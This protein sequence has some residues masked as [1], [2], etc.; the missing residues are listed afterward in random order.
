MDDV[1]SYKPNSFRMLR[2]FWKLSFVKIDDE[3]NKALKD[4]ILK[5]KRG[6]EIIIRKIE[7]YAKTQD[8]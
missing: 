6:S 5:S 1:L 8:K 3:E 2:A 7:Y 4:I